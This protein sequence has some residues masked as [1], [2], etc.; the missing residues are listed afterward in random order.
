MSN[1][2][3]T[4]PLW[5]DTAGVAIFSH[6]VRVKAILWVS[7][8]ASGKD[9]AENDDMK[10]LDESGGNVVFSKKAESNGDG[11]EMNFGERGVMLSGIYISELDGGILLIYV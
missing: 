10:L 4:N 7:D 2:L 3:T 5:V 8:D 1:V 6:S 11:I 9:I